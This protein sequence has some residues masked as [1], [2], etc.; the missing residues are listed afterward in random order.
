[1]GILRAGTS[2]SHDPHSRFCA[3][4]S[5]FSCAVTW[6]S[7]VLHRH[8]TVRSGQGGFLRESDVMEMRA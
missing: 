4:H 8:G 7:V 1:M 5:R 3:M 2:L 6:Q